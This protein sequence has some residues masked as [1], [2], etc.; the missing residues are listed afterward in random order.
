MK[1]DLCLSNNPIYRVKPV[2][3]LLRKWCQIWNDVGKLKKNGRIIYI[4]SASI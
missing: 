4:N 3:L 2:E 1:T